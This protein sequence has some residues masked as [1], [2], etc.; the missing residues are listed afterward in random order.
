MKTINSQS[1]SVTDLE[2][3]SNCRI[4]LVIVYAP[5]LPPPPP[6]IPVEKCTSVSSFHEC[7]ANMNNFDRERFVREKRCETAPKC[8]QIEVSLVPVCCRSTTTFAREVG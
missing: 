5:K 4:N 7:I 3:T 1:C 8:T 6:C 2:D